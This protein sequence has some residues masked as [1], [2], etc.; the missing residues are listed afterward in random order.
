MTKELR[1]KEFL[2]EKELQ[3]S[4]RSNQQKYAKPISAKFELMNSKKKHPESNRGFNDDKLFYKKIEKFYDEVPLSDSQIQCNGL[5]KRSY[6]MEYG[7][8]SCLKPSDNQ[9]AINKSVKLD[10]IVYQNSKDDSHEKNLKLLQAKNNEFREMSP[11][12]KQYKPTKH[13]VVMKQ[14]VSPDYQENSLRYALPKKNAET[15]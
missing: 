12:L 10:P 2:Y 14:L 4:T 1:L 3:L 6:R 15:H 11:Y 5:L 13:S 8:S 7:L 9:I